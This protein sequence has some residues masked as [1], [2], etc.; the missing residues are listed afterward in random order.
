MADQQGIDQL[1]DLLVLPLSLTAQM[2]LCL[3][4]QMLVKFWPQ[5][6]L[7]ICAKQSRLFSTSSASC[8]LSLRHSHLLSYLY[9]WGLLMIISWLEFLILPLL[10]AWSGALADKAAW[11]F[12]EMRVELIYESNSSFCYRLRRGWGDVTLL[13][14]NSAHS[15]PPGTTACSSPSWADVG[16][17]WVAD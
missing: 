11:N 9:A 16:V 2:S 12:R 10:I 13:L 14:E 3:F 6:F 4:V 7:K 5:P 8:L 17:W 1:N 15:C